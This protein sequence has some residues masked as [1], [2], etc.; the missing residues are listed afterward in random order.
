[1]T[2]TNP[3]ATAAAPDP[4]KSA[5]SVAAGQLAA[6]ISAQTG[7]SV[8]GLRAFATEFGPQYAEFA[9]ALAVAKVD[10]D[11]VAFSRAEVD[12][13]ELNDVAVLDA[14]LVAIDAES[15][16]EGVALNVL[17]RFVSLLVSRLLP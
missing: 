1:M 8:D 7:Q 11:A 9:A 10:G 4:M 6:F 17:N 15:A 12:I 5:A 14:A 2:T 13:D 16:G 3:T